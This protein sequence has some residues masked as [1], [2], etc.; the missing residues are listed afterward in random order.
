VRLF[1]IHARLWLDTVDDDVALKEFVVED[2][3]HNNHD[4]P[5]SRILAFS[6]WFSRVNVCV[7]A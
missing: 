3:S 2:G 7:S 1:V 5:S 6:I 4:I